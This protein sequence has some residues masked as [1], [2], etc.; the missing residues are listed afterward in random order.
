MNN[1][2]VRM[3]ENEEI[4][5]DIVSPYAILNLTDRAFRVSTIHDHE[6]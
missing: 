3:N 6:K 2:F 4:E 5:L 1:Y